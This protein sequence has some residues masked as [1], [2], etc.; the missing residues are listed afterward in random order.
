MKSSL[1]KVMHKAA[2]V[3]LA[4]WAVEAAKP[5]VTGKCVLVTGSG[6]ELVKEYFGDTVEY[7]PQEVRLGSGHAVMCAAGHLEGRD[8]YALIMAGD[9]PLITAVTLQSLKDKAEKE[10]LD[11][12]ILSSIADDPAGYGRIL[13]DENG[14]VIKIVEHK[15][16][17]AQ[18][19]NIKEVNASVY[20]FKIPALLDCLSRIRPVNAQGE[21][22]LTDCVELIHAA[23]GRMQAVITADSNEC[24]GVNNRVQLAAVSRLLRQRIN[25]KLMLDGVT[26]VDPDNTYIDPQVKIGMDTTV[27]PGVTLEGDCE[28]GCGVTLYPGSRIK[29][30]F[31][32]DGTTVQNS[33]VLESRIGKKTTIG[34]Y[35]YIRPHCDIGNGC[36]IG[37]F[38]ETKN[39]QIKDG[40]KVSHLSYIGDGYIGENSNIG[41]GVVFVNYDGAKKYRTVVQRD[42][43]VG[44]NANLVA[45]VEIGAG[46][47]VAAGSTV[48]EDV[49]ENT[50]C[51]ARARQVIKTGW[52]RKKKE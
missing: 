47:Y 22:Y 39:A 2:G 10:N 35:A 7:A 8:G 46:A 36:R 25:E 38:V 51:I 43:F 6:A 29:D 4:R 42:V 27:Y 48:T 49:P 23:G 14:D 33:V 9:M 1:P 28:I 20:C 18:Q 32:D 5:V 45:P 41:C 19:R 21:Y 44:C 31:I 13:R 3:P 15:D 17:D 37:D 30:S 40:A 50:L 11:A 12:V 16:A 52:E 34:P 26:L 24:A